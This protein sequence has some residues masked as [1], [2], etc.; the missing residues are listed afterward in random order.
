MEKYAR[1]QG[2]GMWASRNQSPSFKCPG[3]MAGE[4][5]GDDIHRDKRV[6]HPGH[7]QSA[8]VGAEWQR[9]QEGQQQ[10]PVR[11]KR[12]IVTIQEGELA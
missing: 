11:R 4:E 6:G 12:H 8:S 5:I 9:K 3:I 10:K 2:S 1:Q 7:P